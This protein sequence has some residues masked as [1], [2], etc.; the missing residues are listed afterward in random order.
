MNEGEERSRLDLKIARENLLAS[1]IEP[2]WDQLYAD[3]QATSKKLH[4]AYGRDSAV[5]L[6]DH[7]SIIRVTRSEPLSDEASFID[8][9]LEI[10][11]DRKGARIITGIRRRYSRAKRPGELEGPKPYE[12]TPD[13]EANALHFSNKGKLLSTTELAEQEIAERLMKMKL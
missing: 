12:I 1:G 3:V 7:N 8:L 6:N 5:N 11:L 4:D 10:R 2:L 13:V 9:T